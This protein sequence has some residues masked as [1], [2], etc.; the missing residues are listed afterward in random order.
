MDQINWNNGSYIQ[1][2]SEENE[3]QK[4][5][6][7]EPPE[8]QNIRRAFAHQLVSSGVLFQANNN[9]LKMHYFR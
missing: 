3:I 6:L 1:R 9:V 5:F 2:S 4:F 8:S 7:Q